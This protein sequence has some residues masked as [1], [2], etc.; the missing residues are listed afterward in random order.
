MKFG[1]DGQWIC[2]DLDLA[3]G[4][5]GMIG[6]HPFLGRKL[7]EHRFLLLIGST[8]RA[9]LGSGFTTTDAR[10]RCTNTARVRSSRNC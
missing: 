2:G 1:P 8:H 4:P 9:S 6:W 3:D 10:E 7:T 5:Q